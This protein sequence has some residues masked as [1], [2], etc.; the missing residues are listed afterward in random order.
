M[1]GSWPVVLGVIL[2]AGCSSPPPTPPPS[3]APPTP[4]VT[5]PGPSP[6]PRADPQV[7]RIPDA[8]WRAMVAAGVVR[9]DCP[10]GRADL[11]RV[12]V[13]F[14]TFDGDVK[15]GVLVVNRDVAEQV[16]A[17]FT[18]V[19]KARFPMKS[20]RPIE[21]FD[22]DDN[23]SMAANNTSAYNCR[24]ASQANSNAYDSPHANGR[25]VDINPVQN[26]WLDPRC[27][28][29]M[30]TAR[31]AERT[32]GRGKILEGGAVWKAFTARGWIWQDL[33]TPDY[34]HFDTGYP[35][36]PVS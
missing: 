9:A 28:C 2:V 13:N 36:R 27:Q 1:R 29:F 7:R 34:Q 32:P 26:P 10:L 25:A 5:A 12:E 6:R 35:S 33:P 11:R 4:T 30:P 22:G 17:I 14:H 3:S 15:R 21:E 23:A 16:A 20:I 19:F 24:N 8:Q 18:D 31:H